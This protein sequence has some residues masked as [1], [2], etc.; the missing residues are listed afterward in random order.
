[1][2]EILKFLIEAGKLKKIPRTGFVWLGIK[3]PETI[4]GHIFRVAFMNWILAVS[5]KTKLNTKRIIQISLSHDL[6]EVYAGDITPYWGLLPEDKEERQKILK[7]WI[8]LD[9]KSVV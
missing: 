9:R 7:R 8:R 6:C 2:K 1:M 4:A 3:N 5:A